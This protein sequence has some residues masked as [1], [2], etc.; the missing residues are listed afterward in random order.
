MKKF[1]AFTS[2]AVCT[3]AFACES[4]VSQPWFLLDDAKNPVSIYVF[5]TSGKKELDLI[6]DFKNKRSTFTLQPPI[7][8]YSWVYGTCAPGKKRDPSIFAQVKI[9]ARNG[10]AP[11]VKHAYRINIQKGAIEKLPTIDLFCYYGAAGL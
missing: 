10:W 7:N 2:V 5:E 8:G 6:F 11:E 4:I 9:P 3:A 1:L